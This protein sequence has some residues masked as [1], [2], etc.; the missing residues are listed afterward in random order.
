[1]GPLARATKKLFATQGTKEKATA[2]FKNHPEAKW[3]LGFRIPLQMLEVQMT[4]VVDRCSALRCGTR[5]RSNRFGG[6]FRFFATGPD[7][8]EREACEAD[9]LD[10]NDIEEVADVE[11]QAP[12]ATY[13][14]SKELVL[15]AIPLQKIQVQV[16][17]AKH[18]ETTHKVVVK[19]LWGNSLK[20][21]QLEGTTVPSKAVGLGDHS[22]ESEYFDLYR[23]DALSKFE[24]LDPVRFMLRGEWVNGTIVDRY[25]G[26]LVQ[27]KTKSREKPNRKRGAVHH[28]H[29]SN[30]SRQASGLLY[31]IQHKNEC[32][33]KNES[34]D[35]EPWR[36]RHRRAEADDDI[37]QH[38]E[39]MNSDSQHGD[40]VFQYT[41]NSRHG[42]PSCHQEV[43]LQVW[44]KM[45]PFDKFVGY[46]RLDVA[47][48]PVGYNS[49][50]ITMPASSLPE[51]P[52]CNSLLAKPG[53][54][55]LGIVLL[56]NNHHDSNHM[57]GV[58]IFDIR[59]AHVSGDMMHAQ[60]PETQRPRRMMAKRPEP[61]RNTNMPSWSELDGLPHPS[62]L[63]LSPKSSPDRQLP[64]SLAIPPTQTMGDVNEWTTITL[65][66]DHATAATSPLAHEESHD[67]GVTASA[68]VSK[69]YTRGVSH[70]AVKKA[71]GSIIGMFGKRTKKEDNSPLLQQAEVVEEEKEE[72]PSLHF[73]EV[74]QGVAPNPLH[75]LPPAAADFAEGARPQ[76]KHCNKQFATDFG[77]KRH[78]KNEVCLQAKDGD[79]SRASDSAKV[80]VASH[81]NNVPSTDTLPFSPLASPGGSGGA[82]AGSGEGG[83]D[84]SDRCTIEMD[85][86]NDWNHSNSSGVADGAT[87][88]VRPAETIFAQ[89]ECIDKSLWDDS[90]FTNADVT[91]PTEDQSDA[92]NA[93]AV[94]VDSFMQINQKPKP[95]R[96]KGVFGK[97]MRK[98]ENPTLLQQAEVA[99]EE[100]ED[101][102]GSKLTFKQA[103]K[104]S[105][106]PTAV[107]YPLHHLPPEQR[108]N[109]RRSVFCLV[110]AVEGNEKQA[111]KPS[112]TAPAVEDEAEVTL[113][114]SRVIV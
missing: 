33:T 11:A 9:S 99:E 20:E 39:H 17:N 47:T 31:S 21:Q 34:C 32:E 3:A 30:Y 10:A 74:H 93:A 58:H 48:L 6:R 22:W 113:S 54:A 79:S 56:Y 60:S 90:D 106:L 44:I 53:H 102:V 62:S 1:M 85:A 81:N 109:H 78:Y 8:F 29:S 107:D 19:V 42:S 98:A 114:R 77:L 15:E 84:S 89:N 26:N 18:L 97:R 95:R 73:N 61:R 50:A 76:C 71:Q 4:P 75:R 68:D 101:K 57:D 43:V 23:R 5:T 83:A 105:S 91:L 27:G 49:F 16:L 69:L 110:A 40:E 45:L 65:D 36:I 94:V 86:L 38:P 87:K 7:V 24:E 96:G 92:T 72:R 88:D 28:N 103:A 66:D 2:G 111:A 67:N 35:V 46:V 112:T 63:Q 70:L 55:S 80:N 59:R 104:R 52:L 51:A 14:G 12:V 13:S 64:R 37:S 25:H 41:S 82:G 108:H 100:R